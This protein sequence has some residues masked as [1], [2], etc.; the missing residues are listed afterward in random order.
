MESGGKILLA[1][2]NLDIS[3][4]GLWEFPGGK[5]KE[6]ETDEA[7]LMR[8]IKEEMNVDIRVKEF[9]AGNVYKYEDETIELITYKAELMNDD[10]RLTD[11]SEI[12]WVERGDLLKYDLAPADIPIAEK[13]AKEN[14][15]L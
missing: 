12:A 6:G 13:L 10:F 7:C 11:H 9:F 15:T 14:A 1:K 3:M 5:L 8:E 2:R 4:P